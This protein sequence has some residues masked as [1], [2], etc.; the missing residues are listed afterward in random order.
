M[1]D[2]MDKKHALFLSKGN[3][4]VDEMRTIDT[5]REALKQAISDNFPLDETGIQQLKNHV[6]EKIMAVHDI[7][8]TAITALRDAMS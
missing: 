1:R 2:L 3:A 7:E 5:E 6:A 8:K 4:A